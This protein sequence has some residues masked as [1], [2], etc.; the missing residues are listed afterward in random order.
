LVDRL[1]CSIFRYLAIQSQ[2]PNACLSWDAVSSG[3][4]VAARGVYASEHDSM[5]LGIVDSFAPVPSPNLFLLWREHSWNISWYSLSP[6]RAVLCC[7]VRDCGPGTSIASRDSSTGVD[8]Y[9]HQLHQLCYK[10]MPNHQTKRWHECRALRWILDKTIILYNGPW[11]QNDFF[12][13][14]VG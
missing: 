11:F 12:G 2:E 14:C 4:M 3:A 10:P 13:S 1:G 8:C 7:A 6:S 5:L 9:S